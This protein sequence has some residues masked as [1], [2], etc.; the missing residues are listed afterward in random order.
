MERFSPLLLKIL[1]F[2]PSAFAEH[3]VQLVHILV[4]ERTCEHL[5][6]AILDLPLLTATIEFFLKLRR[7]QHQASLRTFSKLLADNQNVLAAYQ[8]VLRNTTSAPQKSQ[9]LSRPAPEVMR[10]HQTWTRAATSQRLRRASDLVPV[11]LGVL[12]KRVLQINSRSI[13][14]QVLEVVV[15]RFCDVYL[16]FFSAGEIHAARATDSA[17]SFS[18]EPAEQQSQQRSQ[19]AV[20]AD[21]DMDTERCVFSTLSD[22]VLTILSR[23]PS[24]LV[25]CRGPLSAAMM[26]EFGNPKAEGLLATTVWAAGEFL[27]TARVLVGK[28]SCLLPVPLRFHPTRA[29]VLLTEHTCVVGSEG[30]ETGQTAPV[31]GDVA[32]ADATDAY[33]RLFVRVLERLLPVHSDREEEAASRQEF[34]LQPP[35]CLL[36]LLKT[37]RRPA[38]LPVAVMPDVTQTP[39]IGVRPGAQAVPRTDDLGRSRAVATATALEAPLLSGQAPTRL[40]LALVSAMT[41]IAAR[42]QEWAPLVKA[43]LARVQATCR[44]AAVVQR[45]RVCQVVLSQPSVAHALLRL[46]TPTD[47]EEWLFT[48]SFIDDSTP[49]PMMTLSA[50]LR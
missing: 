15:S 6:Q 7:P 35:D 33:L 44:H 19:R 5:L 10:S 48:T 38:A 4:S 34:L 26:E 41:K 36:G 22:M 9:R 46:P 13:C 47:S 25:E 23:H 30:H 39:S 11:L 8:Y 43:S 31:G 29:H 24:L 2:Q 14:R 12:F 37:R 50:A 17:L 21:A 49:L 32:S 45:A 1:A 16:P 27:A 20:P 42:C 28:I 40:L 18:F 3:F